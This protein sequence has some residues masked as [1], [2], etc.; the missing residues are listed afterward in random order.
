MSYCRFLNQFRFKTYQSVLLF[1]LLLIAFTGCFYPKTVMDND[2]QCKLTTK[3][4][5]LEF[6]DEG[7]Q[8]TAQG[9]LHM[10]RGCNEPECL[11]IVP[12]GLVAVPVT[13]FTVSGSIVVVGNTLHWIE[14]QGKCEDS[15]TKKALRLLMKTTK[16][17][18]GKVIH[19]GKELALWLKQ[20]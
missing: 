20:I 17:L 6:S 13:S 19:S 3:K 16:S 7:S 18:G 5:T 8:E 2:R 12:I 9:M 11:Y 1:A 14:Q 4:L 10:L 15:A